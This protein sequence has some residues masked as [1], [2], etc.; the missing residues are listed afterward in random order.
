MRT[1]SIH[2]AFSRALLAL[3]VGFCGASVGVRAQQP[4]AEQAQ[5]LPQQ[6]GSATQSSHSSA[7]PKAAAGEQGVAA[8]SGEVAGE[9]SEYS[10]RGATVRVDLR[11]FR[12]PSSAY[13]VY[14]AELTPDMQASTEGPNTA[15]D[16]DKLVM[17]A[18]EFVVAIH[19]HRAL[20]PDDLHKLVEVIRKHADE[21]PLPP[22]RAFLPSEGLVQGSQR[23]ALGPEAFR[24]ALTALHHGEMD[25]L[26]S[27]VGFDKGAEAMLA[28]FRGVADEAV[29][30]LIDYPTPQLAEQ[31][32]RHLEVA[33]PDSAK[34]AGT[35]IQRKGSLLT[36]VIAPTSAQYAVNLRDS[37]NYG[38]MVTWN[39]PSHTITDPPW[40]V[41]LKNI[42]LGTFLFCAVAIA[43][44]VAFGG[45]RVI[46]KRLLPGKV[47]DRPQDLEVLQLGLTG[48]PIDPKDLY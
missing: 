3:T 33:M 35:T 26:T 4:P 39:E 23:Y 17:L 24:S 46:T 37:L 21:T 34:A 42:F 40:V 44:G 45:V 41:V 48:K 36:L 19:N 6:A 47:F 20:S 15:V 14:T 12:D 29:L 43:L 1:N 11:K 31:H 27:E 30:A 32:L 5:V 22:I 10:V 8:E 9:S 16:K 7:A 2:S 28:K 18:G 38:T 25:A 13:E